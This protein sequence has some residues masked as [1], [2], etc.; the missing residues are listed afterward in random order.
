[1]QIKEIY[2]LVVG[3]TLSLIGMGFYAFEFTWIINPSGVGGAFIGGGVSLIII[4]LRE[5]RLRDKGTIVE[6][7]RIFRIAEKSSHKSLMILI[8]LEGI[9][10]AL[11]GV[12]GYDVQAYPIVSLLFAI[13]A[14]LYVGFY[15]WYKRQM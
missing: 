11:L 1:M 13:T 9:L 14:I 6:D 2:M 15:F 12:T 7:E 8:I 3:F 10:V 4:T 5:I